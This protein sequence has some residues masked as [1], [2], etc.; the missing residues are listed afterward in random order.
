MFL[1]NFTMTGKETRGIEFAK[2]LSYCNIYN[3]INRDTKK[4][5]N[6]KKPSNN[7]QINK[8]PTQKTNNRK[9]SIQISSYFATVHYNAQLHAKSNWRLMSKC[10]ENNIIL[11]K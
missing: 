10:I 6:Q 8:H 4:L 2:S 1:I 7:H 5:K 3:C 9:K 11:E